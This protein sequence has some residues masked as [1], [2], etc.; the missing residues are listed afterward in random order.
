MNTQLEAIMALESGEEME[1][2]EQAK[3][4]QLLLNE[5]QWSLQ[6]SYGRAM[7]AALENGDNMLGTEP[8][9]DAYGNFIPSRDMVEDGTKGSR[10]LVVATHGEEWAKALE[11][12]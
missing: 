6:G 4:M 3:A 8:A 12:L 1:P 2:L 11:S 10:G 5:G 7:M 9:H